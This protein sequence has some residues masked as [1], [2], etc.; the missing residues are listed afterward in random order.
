[1]FL[2]FPLT[3]VPLS[4]FHLDGTPVSTPKSKLFHHLVEKIP[5]EMSPTSTD[6]VIIDGNF[7]LNALCSMPLSTSYGALARLILV[8]L[9]TLS[10]HRVDLVF[11]VYRHPSKKDSERS[12]QGQMNRTYSITGPEQQLPRKLSDAMKSPSFKE[13]LP[14]FLVNE[15]QKPQYAPILKQCHLFVG[16][17]QECIH[18]YCD[19]NVIKSEMYKN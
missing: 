12:K 3:P 13:S 5:T 9:T 18:F 14:F 15:W 6:C 19:G 16:Y 2:S 1:M 8:R 4:L 17:S 11:D 10:G 7:F